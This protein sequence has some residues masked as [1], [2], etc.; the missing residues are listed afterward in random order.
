MVIDRFK[1]L[2]KAVS[3]FSALK[4]SELEDDD[5][6]EEDLVEELEEIFHES[7][8]DE[9]K[10]AKKDL[11]KGLVKVK[12]E[13][14]T[15]S[16]LEALLKDIAVLKES[17][18]LIEQLIRHVDKLHK[19]SLQTVSPN[20]AQ[21][22][23]SRLTANTTKINTMLTNA[24]RAL[25]DLQAK[26][27]TVAISSKDSVIRIARVQSM[28]LSRKLLDL[29]KLWHQV[30]SSSRA[31]AR[32]H[33]ERQFLIIKP[34][35]TADDLDTL[36]QAAMSS[37]T[38]SFNALLTQQSMFAPHLEAGQVLAQMRAQRD[39]MQRIEQGLQDINQLMLQISLLVQQQGEWIDRL[40]EHVERTAEYAGKSA[41]L[42]KRAVGKKKKGQVLKWILIVVI[43][44]V[45]VAVLGVL[46]FYL[47]PFFG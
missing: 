47:K 41:R 31:R 13:L 32:A 14:S 23:H 45:I 5:E 33:L 4:K 27:T 21:D 15:C 8:H 40:Q 35:A 24:R 34:E 20:Q 3:H 30:E 6:E 39:E 43:I 7:D 37:S 19:D 9:D 44:L 46:S 1:D 2:S 18:P 22:L 29:V 11:E 36:A 16:R 17:L 10:G 28:H 25:E 42:V 38:S 12:S 26:A